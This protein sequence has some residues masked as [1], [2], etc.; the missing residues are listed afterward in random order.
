MKPISIGLIGIG[1]VVSNLTNNLLKSNSDLVRF[2]CIW[3]LW[4]IGEFEIVSQYLDIKN[5]KSEMI[6]QEYQ[7]L[8]EMIYSNK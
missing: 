6:L 2:Y 4:K 1:N 7:R 3:G 8:N 5:E